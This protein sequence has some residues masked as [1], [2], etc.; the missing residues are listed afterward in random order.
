M[1][2]RFATD[3]S[4]DSLRRAQLNP[5]ITHGQDPVEWARRAAL[6]NINDL[7]IGMDSSLAAFST[8][9]QQFNAVNPD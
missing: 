4:D 8:L 7:L 9:P 5:N 3:L 2:D 6:A 1:R